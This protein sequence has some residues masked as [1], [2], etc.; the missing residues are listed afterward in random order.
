MREMFVVLSVEGSMS[1]NSNQDNN[2]TNTNQG[3][4]PQPTSPVPPP[5]RENKKPVVVKLSEPNDGK[6]TMG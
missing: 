1:Q 2:Q 3:Q 4:S 6:R 5:I